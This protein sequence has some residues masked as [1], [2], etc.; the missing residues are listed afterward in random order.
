MLLKV[1]TIQKG[2]YVWDGSMASGNDDSLCV[3]MASTFYQG[4]KEGESPRRALHSE[5]LVATKGPVNYCGCISRIDR[6]YISIVRASAP[7]WRYKI[8]PA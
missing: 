4:A 5:M 8:T 2:R 1:L 7:T 6:A 3:R